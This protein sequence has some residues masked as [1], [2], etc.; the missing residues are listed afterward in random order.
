MSHLSCKILVS[1]NNASTPLCHACQLGKH[2]R[3]PFSRSKTLC[4]IPFKLIH[5]Y[6]WTS[7]VLSNTGFKYYLVVVDDYSHYMWTF[8]FVGNQTHQILSSTS[9]PMHALSLTFL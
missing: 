6:L 8:R 3:L 4:V 2:V 5:C 1:C 9:L 7:P